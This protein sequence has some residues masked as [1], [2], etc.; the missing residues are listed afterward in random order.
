MASPIG[1]GPLFPLSESWSLLKT[2]WASLSIPSTKSL[3]NSSN[4][5]DACDLT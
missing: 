4:K 3:G 2:L 1:R 5:S